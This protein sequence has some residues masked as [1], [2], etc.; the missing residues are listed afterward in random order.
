MEGFTII[1]GVVADIR[2]GKFTDE[3]LETAKKMILCYDAL[4]K[5][6]NEAVAMG[7]ALSELYGDGWDSDKK[8]YEGIRKTTREDVVRIAN[9]VFG[10][11][12]LRI[13]IRPAGP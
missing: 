13:F 3:E 7:D 2:A 6:E 9:R 8:Y 5:A 11:P 4:G 1:D 10:S 12:A